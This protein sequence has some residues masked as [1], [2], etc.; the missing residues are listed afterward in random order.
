M[1]RIT[2]ILIIG[3]IIS[4]CNTRTSSLSETVPPS[5]QPDWTGISVDDIPVEFGQV[6]KFENDSIVFTAVVLDFNQD[7]GGKW[8][9]LCFVDNNRLFG[10]QIPNGIVNT[11]CLDLL[12]FSYLQIDGLSDFQIVETLKIDKNKV[13]IGLISPVLNLVE[14]NRDYNYGIEQRKKEQTP[15]DKR[16]TDLNPVRE[17]YFNIEKI[18]TSH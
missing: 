2:Y 3:L 15:Y 5:M 17:C 4:S 9:G 14:L 16:L 18:K 13:G 10:R 11:I 1:T 12:D 7:E 6:L 8:I